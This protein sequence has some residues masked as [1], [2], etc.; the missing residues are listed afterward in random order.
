MKNGKFDA[1]D[2]RLQR[3][4]DEVRQLRATIEAQIEPKGWQSIAGS[5]AGDPVFAEITRLGREIRESERRKAR[6]GRKAVKR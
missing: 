3:L 2:Q 5:H 6:R 4:E 1:L